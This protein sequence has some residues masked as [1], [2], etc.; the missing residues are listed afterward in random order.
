M[1]LQVSQGFRWCRG[2]RR[3]VVTVSGSTK[4]EREVKIGFFKASCMKIST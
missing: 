2:A 4:E 1:E 3:A